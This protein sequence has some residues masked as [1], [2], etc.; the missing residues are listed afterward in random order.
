MNS[1]LLTSIRIG[2]VLVLWMPIIV[3]PETF[4][5]Y[6]VGKA[7]YARVTIEIITAAW[8]VLALREPI[9]RPRL[10]WVLLVFGL[11][12]W[13]AFVSAVAGVSFAH[14][15]WSDYS[16]MVGVWDLFHWFLFALVAT[17]VLRSATAWRSVLNWNLAVSL[18][19]SLVALAQAYNL[20]GVSFQGRVYATTGNPSYLAA[21]L[22]ATTL[23]A[24]GFLARSFVPVTDGGPASPVR[25]NSGSRRRPSPLEV[26]SR[27]WNRSERQMLF[28]RVFW[29]VTAALGVWVLF[30]TGTRG[31]LV[32]LMAGALAMPVALA[33]FGNR[34]ALMPI[35]LAASGVLL[36]VGLLFALDQIPGTSIQPSS[37]TE[38]TAARFVSTRI[39][40]SN[41]AMRL[42][43]IGVAIKGFLDR[44]ILGWGHDNF[45]RAYD[46]F[47]DASF[48]KY[49]TTSADRS[50]NKVADDLVTKGA[51]G[52]VVYGALWA[53]LVWAVVR[54][55]REP[56]EEIL[57]YAVLGALAG[58]F[59]Q[60][61]FL[62]D[63]AVTLLQW[64]LLLS[65]VIGQERAAIETTEKASIGPRKGGL[66]SR[67][68]RR[69]TSQL[70]IDPRLHSAVVVAVVVLLGFSLYSLNYRPFL[71]ARLFHQAY[72]G[73]GVLEDDLTLA[74]RSFEAFPAMATKPRGFMLKRLNTQWNDM[75]LEQRRV[76]LEFVYEQAEQI[77]STV[78]DNARLISNI[79]PV[80]QSVAVSQ[81]RLEGL[82]PLLQR[83]R[84]LA[85]ERV[86]TYEAL[87]VQELQKGNHREALRIVDEF[88]AIAPWAPDL[89]ASVRRAA[90]EGL[91][92]MN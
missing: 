34:K 44:P 92:N 66:T 11:Y 82:E 49:G 63:T 53:L 5:H 22:T 58:Y 39:E 88:E 4:F 16:R 90:E 26:F 21:I 48:Y 50:H 12:V 51:L 33:I 20:F 52:I 87:A 31:A 72:N 76:A 79:L 10:S 55:R 65:W 19:L 40:E 41:V 91:S 86:Y 64:V 43:L 6:V 57:A 32:G 80:L 77:L 75:N 18:V 47:A 3:V 35:V 61:L 60:N 9:Y 13:T 81:E 54:R 85:P 67:K 59:V 17:S 74:R 1:Y 14:S 2:I 69:L 42:K 62:F 30:L 28:W 83:L 7:I 84:Q 46:R 37:P 56:Q 73:S 25:G 71:G 89:L 27:P 78:P 70:L 36:G 68:S 45:P 29:T 24:A 15:M 38:T 23:I 8:V